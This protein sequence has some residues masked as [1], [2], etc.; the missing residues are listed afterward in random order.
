MASEFGATPAPTGTEP[1]RGPRRI[2]RPGAPLA[3]GSLM[4]SGH[5]PGMGGPL[6]RR[7]GEFLL[8]SVVGSDALGTVFRALPPEGAGDFVRLRLF[9]SPDLPRAAVAAALLSSSGAPRPRSSPE[10]ARDE[11]PGIAGGV[12]FL[13]WSESHAQSLDRLLASRPGHEF[14][15]AHALLIADRM[16]RALEQAHRSH[17]FHGLL[18]PGFVTLDPDG[19]VRVGG[20][21]VAGAVL[22]WLGAPRL[23]REIAPYV[24]PESRGVAD[25]KDLLPSADVYALGSILF[26]LLTGRRPPLRFPA[27]KLPGPEGLPRFAGDLLRDA[28][29]AGPSRTPTPTAFRVAIGAALVANG[30]SPS[31]RELG[32]LVRELMDAESGED[33]D[34]PEAVGVFSVGEA[35]EE[36]DWDRALARLEPAAESHTRPVP[37][38]RVKAHVPVP[39]RPASSLNPFR[40]RRKPPAKE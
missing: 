23:S 30:L 6:P 2:G 28:L 38:S 36:D 13:A 8:T 18:W 5:G 25:A 22:P 1:G 10:L 27:E 11:R 33:E 32:V 26:E 39:A 15:A 16:A 12:A 3:R 9:D 34:A 37:R 31:S 21:G 14:A 19:A 17:I 24:A 7:A 20:F 35:P 4:I 40:A 29:A